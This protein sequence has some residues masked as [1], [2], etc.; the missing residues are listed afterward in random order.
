EEKRKKEKK[1]EKKRKKEKKRE[2]K[3]KKREE[4]RRK[5]KR[6]KEKKEKKR[7]EKRRKEKKPVQTPQ[8]HTCKLNRT[9]CSLLTGLSHHLVLF[10]VKPYLI[11]STEYLEDFS[12][13]RNSVETERHTRVNLFL[14]SHKSD[15]IPCKWLVVD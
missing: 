14:F 13:P 8:M 5:E 4:K 10:V 2:R 3:E 11:A 9:K 7:E 1:R 12:A 15:C 6:R